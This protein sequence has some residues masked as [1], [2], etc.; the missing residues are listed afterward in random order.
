MHER[1]CQCTRHA[2]VQLLH[3]LLNLATNNNMRGCVGEEEQKEGRIKI[4]TGL[5][6]SAIHPSHKHMRTYTEQLSHKYEN[7]HARM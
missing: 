4:K 6:T 3:I 1:K 2:L 7:I 5:Y